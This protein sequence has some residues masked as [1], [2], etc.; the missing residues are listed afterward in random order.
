MVDV[1][2]PDEASEFFFTCQCGC[3]RRGY[4]SEALPIV[5]AAELRRFAAEAHEEAQGYPLNTTGHI[6]RRDI[7]LT[8][9]RMLKL[10]AAE[11]DGES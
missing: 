6:T 3:G 1:K 4:Q 2:I 9:A 11:L 10:R 7:A 8:Y 5:V